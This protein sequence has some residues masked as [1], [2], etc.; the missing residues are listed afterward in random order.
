MDKYFD[1]EGDKLLIGKNSVTITVP[2]GAVAKGDQVQIQAAASLIGPYIIPE[3][4]HPVSAF[5]WIGASYTF[6]KHVLVE[7]EHHA[8][9]SQQEDFLQMSMLTAC[10]QDRVT[11]SDGRDM[12][13]MHEPTCQPHCTIKE[14]VFIYG[15]N[16]FCSNCIAKRNEKIPDKVVVYHMLSKLYESADL[17]TSEICFCYNLEL[18]RKVINLNH[19]ILFLLSLCY[20]CLFLDS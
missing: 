9:L 10:H 20:V 19:K 17:F 7:I 13:T 16:N 12:Y 1:A 11:R 3:G 15:T 18:C 4:Y 2:K 8:A 5:V 6:K 14:S